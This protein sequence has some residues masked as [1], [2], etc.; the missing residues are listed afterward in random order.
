M[1]GFLCVDRGV[2]LPLGATPLEEGVNFAVFS[3]H[4]TH[5][6]LSLFR[7]GKKLPF[8]EIPLD[9]GANRTGHIWHVWISGLPR[10][11]LYAW[12]MDMRPNPNPAIHRFDPSV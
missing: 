11:V 12:R 5:V 3:K 9:P 6:W 8:H 1:A 4:A 10:D 7:P 2:A